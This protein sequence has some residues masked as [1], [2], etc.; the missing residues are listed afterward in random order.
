MER[1]GHAQ[2]LKNVVLGGQARVAG[3]TN[4]PCGRQPS[5]RHRKSL[6]S[7]GHLEA[8]TDIHNVDLGEQLGGLREL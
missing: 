6:T 1:E 7:V 4:P 5:L 2:P 8:V 3:K